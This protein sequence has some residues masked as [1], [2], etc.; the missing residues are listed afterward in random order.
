MG[1]QGLGRREGQQ[2]HWQNHGY[3]DFEATK[4]WVLKQHLPTRRANC[5]GVE[6]DLNSGNAAAVDFGQW[7]PK[8][9]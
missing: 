8:S 6:V 9:F 4:R 7:R 3:A 1:E 2:Y 5:F